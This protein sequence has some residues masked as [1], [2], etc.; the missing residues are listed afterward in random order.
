M[1]N[2]KSIAHELLAQEI[3]KN[4]IGKITG[5][6]ADYIV[7]ENPENRYFVGK[8][9]PVSDSQTSSW[10]SDVFIESIGADFYITPDEISSAQLTI[11]PRGDFYYRAYPTLEQQR[12]AMLQKANEL[13][14]P[15]FTDFEELVSKYQ[16]DPSAFSKVK[17]KLVPVYKK[18]QIHK[19]ISRLCFRCMSF[20][21][22]I[23][24]MAMQMQI[25]LKI[26][27]SSSISMTFNQQL[28]R[29]N[30]AILTS[31]MKKRP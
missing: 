21:K 11:Y 23:L 14:E 20:W 29:M 18:V 5:D 10:G 3:L 13:F 17:E 9:L 12:T 27:N 22:A 1:A 16:E 8:L 19:T 7:G 24:N 4:F 2:E 28:W 30:I 31:C 26:S 6:N 15:R 25:T